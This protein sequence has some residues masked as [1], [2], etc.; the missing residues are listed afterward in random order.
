M[1]NTAEFPVVFARLKQILVP[2]AS[3]GVKLDAP[4]DYVIEGPPTDATVGR[5]AY[6]GEVRIRKNYVSFYLMPVYAFPDLLD[7]ASGDLKKR[8]QGKSCFNFTKI[9]EPLF[10]ELEDLAQRGYE[11]YLEAGFIAGKVPAAKGAR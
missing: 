6:F 2:F 7:R 9:D 5:P 11:R 4:D 1:A 3:I 8:M 10:S